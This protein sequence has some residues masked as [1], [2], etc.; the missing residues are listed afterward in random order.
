MKKQTYASPMSYVGSARRIW[1]WAR[2]WGDAN[3]VTAAFAWA[4]IVLAIAG[5]WIFVTVWYCVTLLLFSWLLFPYRLI[6]RSH[7][8]QEQLQRQQLATMQAMMIQ[9]QQALQQS[10]QRD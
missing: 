1:S 7:R 5:M 6:R 3:P 9:Q 8:K 2:G 10:Q 4:F